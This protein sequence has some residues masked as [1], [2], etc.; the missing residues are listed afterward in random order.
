[1]S[2]AALA[3]FAA[4]AHYD[5]KAR[6]DTARSTVRVDASIRIPNPDPHIEFVLGSTY[7]IDEL[8]ASDGSV[9]VTPGDVQTIVID[10]ARAGRP[11]TLHIKHHG[12][13]APSGT[14][15]LN[16]IGADR[17]ELNLDSS[18][19]PLR[20]GF[21]TKFTADVSLSGLPA[22]AVV[23]APGVVSRTKIERRTPDIDVAF[24]AIPGL[25]RSAL[26]G[27]ELY[28]IDLQSPAARVYAKHASSAM[29]FEERWF[30]Q[31]AAK[32]PVRVVVVRRERRSG[33]ARPGYIVVT[34]QADVVEVR[35]AKF[36]AHELA[37][38]WWAPADPTTEHR[39]LQESIAEY[40]ALR[41]V[42]SA[43]GVAARDEM[44]Q[45]KRTTAATA[46]PLLGL[47]ARTD[48][49]LYAKA[50]LL[51]FD[52][53]SQIGR[54]KLDRVLADLGR[55]PPSV[56]SQFLERL[57]AVAGEDAAEAFE[58]RLRE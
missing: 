58:K 55:N 6:L 49:E 29:A 13:L 47:G 57:R 33:Y 31:P 39:W 34:E 18:W 51:L 23:V 2:F 45:A 11:L 54:K 26:P 35:A 17:V 43:F 53:E 25:Q 21:T 56:T 52:V 50:P 30:G 1:M 7:A 32:G 10:G 42:E 38:S 12:S 20:A 40:V 41:Y 19:L 36:I 46:T 8:R 44:L 5:V 4:L 16:A 37:H 27:V 28:A 24:V 9:K 15:P 14:P 48:A 22:H 3:L